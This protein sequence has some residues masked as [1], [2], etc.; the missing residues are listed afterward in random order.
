MR[1]TSR[2]K[3]EFPSYQLRKV[4]QVWYIQLKDNRLVESGPIE[5]EEYKEAFLGKY[6]PHEWREVKVEEFINNRQGNM[7]VEE[8]SLKFTL[9]YKYASYLVFNS[10]DEMSRFVTGVADLV[11]EE[12][13]TTILHGDMNFSMLMVFWKKHFGK[14][15]V[16]IRGCF[17]CGKDGHKVKDCPTITARGREAKKVPPSA[18]EEDA[19]KRNWFYVL[20]AKLAK[21]GRL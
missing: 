10:R 8:Y 13:R 2:D 14:C 6:F 1:V 21:F 3:A 16:G 7:S 19:P 15:L 4:A 18:P 9:L 17:D 12:C 5:W 11:K 20:Q